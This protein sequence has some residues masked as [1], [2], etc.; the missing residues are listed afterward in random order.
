MRWARG[1]HDEIVAFF[2]HV[3]PTPD[4]RHAR[5]VVI[6]QVAEVIRGRLPR[7][8]VDT[9]G[10]VAQDLYL[11]DGDTD[12][13][14]TVPHPYDDETKRRVLF[15]LAA[16]MRS[17]GVTDHT[18]VVAHA[19]VPLISF[20]TFPDLGSLK[21]DISMNAPDGLR[22]VPILRD[23]FQR[24]PALR[25][26]VM[27]L[28]SLLSRHGLNSAS[29]SG[30]SSYALILLTLSF[31]QLNPAGRPAAYID[32][33]LESES[34]GVLLTDFLEYYADEFPYETSYVSVTEGKLMSKEDKG[35]VNPNN[36][37]KVSIEC[38]LNPDNDVGRPTSK[39]RKIRALFRDA[40][41]LVQAYPFDPASSSHNILGTIVGVS[42]S[43]SILFLHTTLVAHLRPYRLSPTACF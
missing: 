16:R 15:Q 18:H 1:L 20:K 19:R 29:S 26:L 30:L 22:A 5:A 14:I 41:A 24:V 6:A 39:I 32:Q 35:W 12:L 23:Y 4:E 43:V 13:V 38:L 9:F 8:A 33:P 37:E 28:K 42:E 40:R 25:Y 17:T 31:L 36:P 2:A 7:A 3:A 11:P 10:S 34:L 21:I 27:T